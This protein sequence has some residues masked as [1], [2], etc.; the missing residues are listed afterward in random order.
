VSN[1]KEG[2]GQRIPNGAIHGDFRFGDKVF[3]ASNHGMRC[4]GGSRVGEVFG[5]VTVKETGW[6]R[7]D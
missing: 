6:R 1:G 4:R 5:E 7:W 2:L 3:G